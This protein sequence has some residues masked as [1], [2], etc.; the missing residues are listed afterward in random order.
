MLASASLVDGMNPAN[1]P[2]LRLNRDRDAVSTELDCASVHLLC[3]AFHVSIVPDLFE[4]SRLVCLDHLEFSTGE[5]RLQSRL[6]F[7]SLCPCVKRELTS[8]LPTIDEV[9]DVPPSQYDPLCCHVFHSTIVI[10]ICQPPS[11][12]FLKFFLTGTQA[13][14]LHK[15]GVVVERHHAVLFHPISIYKTTTPGPDEL[16][17]YIKQG[18]RGGGYR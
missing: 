9:C 1:L 14:P 17:R 18:G 6:V 2:R 13:R 3:L 15:S 8:G 16:Y 4:L 11:L 5:I 12:G 10:G 7:F